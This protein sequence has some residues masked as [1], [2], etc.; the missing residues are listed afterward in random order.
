MYAKHCGSRDY[1]FLKP[2]LVLYEERH[3]PYDP[4][5]VS[6]VTCARGVAPP[7]FRVT[8]RSSRPC[9]TIACSG[10]STPLRTR[11]ASYSYSY[12]S[13]LKLYVVPE[14]SSVLVSEVV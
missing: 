2:R 11:S 1:S 12:S 5:A 3:P 14:L 6:C 8:A 10:T 4:V 13:S 9:A 7:G